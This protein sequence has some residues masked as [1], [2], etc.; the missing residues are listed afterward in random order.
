MEE[1]ME[2]LGQD[3]VYS[4]VFTKQ[5]MMTVQKKKN[6]RSQEIWPAVSAALITLG[7]ATGLSVLSYTS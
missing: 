1:K 6:S 7:R 3:K 4:M 2:K 5:T